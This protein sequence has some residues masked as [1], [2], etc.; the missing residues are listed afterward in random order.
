MS[1]A[2]LGRCQGYR[3][4]G[5]GGSIGFVDEVRRDRDGAALLAVGAG[6]VGRRLL[7]FSAADVASVAPRT[8]R[9]L[10]R[11]SATPVASEPKL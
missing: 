6:P 1:T 2:E 10:L 11:S 8:T 3:V 9:I 4:D 7:I 5:A